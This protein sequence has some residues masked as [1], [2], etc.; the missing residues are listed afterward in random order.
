MPLKPN[1]RT[2]QI[3]STRKAD[4]RGGERGKGG[5]GEKPVGAG[6]MSAFVGFVFAPAPKGVIP[7]CEKTLYIY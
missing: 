2:P 3:Q 1:P 4:K 6:E 7:Q 5:L